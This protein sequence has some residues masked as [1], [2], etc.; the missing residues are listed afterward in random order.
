M[1]QIIVCNIDSNHTTITLDC[2]FLSTLF[3]L[4]KSISLSIPEARLLEMMAN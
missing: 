3:K 1:K 4:I 2:I